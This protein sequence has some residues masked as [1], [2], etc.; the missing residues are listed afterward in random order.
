ME[1]EVGSFDVAK[2]DAILAR[3]LSSGMGTSEG[4]MCI[5]AAVCQVLGLPHGDDPQC[6]SVA[7]RS[8]KIALN[9]S[10]WSSPQARAKGLRDLGLAQLGSLGVVNDVEFSKRIATRTI[11]VLIPKLFR[12]VCADSP[13]CMAAA[14]ECELRPSAASA[15]NAARGAMVACLESAAWAA[16]C[17]SDASDESASRA[18]R[19][20]WEE[21]VV[22]A[23]RSAR[24]ARAARAEWSD[25][26]LILSA[27]LALEILRD[28]GSPGCSLIEGRV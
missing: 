6:V 3:G 9:D 4:S 11:Q 5:E 18:A 25:E 17:A 1:F 22:M 20:G 21:M 19:I 8:Y 7:V 14:L 24:L 28:M 12:E 2:F 26:Y 15:E 23:A 10:P 27:N 13:D 16:R